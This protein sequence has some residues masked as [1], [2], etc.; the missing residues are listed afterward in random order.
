MSI[1]RHRDPR[2]RSIED[3]INY[4]VGK[5]VFIAVAGGN[6]FRTATRRKSIAEI[7]SR[8]QGAVSV[9]AV[10]RN[11]GARALL[12][13]RDLGRAV[14][15]GRR[16]PRLR[17][18]RRHPAADARPRSRRNVRPAARRVRADAAAFRFAGLFLFHRH[19]VGHAARRRGGGHVDAAGH[20][21]PGRHRGGARDGSRST[22]ATRD[23][24]RHSGSG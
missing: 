1:G 4:A 15:A 20:H 8:V 18:D 12:E 6:E 11:K 22:S 7:A 19:V 16:V 5:G 9:A 21:G 23:A 3:A 2:R 17:S 14:G 13:H 24:I 10:D